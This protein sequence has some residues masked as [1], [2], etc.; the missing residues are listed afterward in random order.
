LPPGL[1][2]LLISITCLHFSLAWWADNGR[3]GVADQAAHC[4]EVV[5]DNDPP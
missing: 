1:F 3:R 2:T 4:T 5:H